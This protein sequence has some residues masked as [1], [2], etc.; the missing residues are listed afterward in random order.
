MLF[1]NEAARDVLIDEK[2]LEDSADPL[3]IMNY[4][5]SSFIHDFSL[6]NDNKTIVRF[7]KDF[8]P[9]DAKRFLAGVCTVGFAT[10]DKFS[11]KGLFADAISPLH[12]ESDA[13]SGVAIRITQG[14]HDTTREKRIRELVHEN[15]KEIEERDV[16]SELIAELRRA[17]PFYRTI[18]SVLV[19]Y[20][21][22]NTNFQIDAF[23]FQRVINK[24]FKAVSGSQ[25]S[26]EINCL[27]TPE[28]NSRQ[29]STL[30]IFNGA[31]NFEI[32]ESILEFSKHSFIK[33]GEVKP[34]FEVAFNELLKSTSTRRIN[35]INDELT[36]GIEGVLKDSNCNMVE[37]T[38]VQE[39]ME[40]LNHPDVRNIL[41][42]EKLEKI[43]I[44]R[45]TLR[46]ALV[47]VVKQFSLGEM[48]KRLRILL[49][50]H[51]MSK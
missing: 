41:N 5:I 10:N 49:L 40:L 20:F 6:I 36:T 4:Y 26:V 34:D 15:L 47:E 3:N 19:F 37:G 21:I 13:L 27:Y 23:K 44:K 2:N 24:F 46:S 14:E 22:K 12:Y 8:D 43:L 25:V 42:A 50:L 33:K 17:T 35:D 32:Y 18:K 48:K 30:V 45:D 31:F 16:D 9:M 1:S 29:N 38:D 51:L 7:G 39:D 11:A 28:S